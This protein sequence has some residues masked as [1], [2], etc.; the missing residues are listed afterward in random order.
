[1]L[2]FKTMLSAP[3]AA[4]PSSDAPLRDAPLRG[5]SGVTKIALWAIRVYQRLISPALPASCRFYPTCSHY[6]YEAI[7]R[8]GLWRGGWLG[9]KRLC[10]CNPFHPGGYDPVPLAPQA[11]A[12]EASADAKTADVKTHEPIEDESIGG[13]QANERAA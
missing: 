6:T 10:R 13:P 2:R 3:D 5:S 9:L 12:S 4:P 1:M 7:A 11:S 8:L